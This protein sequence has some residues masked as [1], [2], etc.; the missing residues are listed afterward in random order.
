MFCFFINLYLLIV[1]RRRYLADFRSLNCY[2][3]YRL[4]NITF[5]SLSSFWNGSIKGRIKSF[6]KLGFG[7]VVVTG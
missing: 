5:C 6:K 2:I 3:I 1:V 7:V 4:E